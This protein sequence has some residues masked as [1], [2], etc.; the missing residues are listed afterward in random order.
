MKKLIKIIS[1]IPCSLK[2]NKETFFVNDCIFLEIIDEEKVLL[3]AE[4]LYESEYFGINYML[5]DKLKPHK[6]VRITKYK[7]NVKLE[8]FFQSAN[9]IKHLES[10]DYSITYYNNYYLIQNN[11]YFLHYSLY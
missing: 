7:N 11:N 5:S 6:N 3:K 10:N 2:A 1:N 8:F 4:P 9:K